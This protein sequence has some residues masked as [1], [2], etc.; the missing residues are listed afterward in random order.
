MKMAFSEFGVF[1]SPEDLRWVHPIMLVQDRH[2]PRVRLNAS[3]IKRVT[4]CNIIT[5]FPLLVGIT[6]D[7]FA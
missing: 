3:C 5:F 7:V 1:A 6:V 2:Q 4:V